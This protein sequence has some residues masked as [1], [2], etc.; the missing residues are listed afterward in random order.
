MSQEIKTNNKLDL[1]NVYTL[2]G[3]QDETSYELR[4]YAKNSFNHS[5]PTEIETITTLSQGNKVIYGQTGSFDVVIRIERKHLYDGS[6]PEGLK[7]NEL[8]QSAEPDS[9]NTGPNAEYAEVSKP[10]KKPSKSTNDTYAEVQK[11]N[12]VYAEVDKKTQQKNE[13]RKKQKGN[14]CF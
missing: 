3:L 11:Q 9:I 1:H 13:K 4:M 6:E 10:Y 12:D 14:R 8:Y 7:V 5:Q 2:S